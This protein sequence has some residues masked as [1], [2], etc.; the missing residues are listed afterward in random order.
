M[1]ELPWAEFKEQILSNPSWSILFFNVAGHYN[2][3]AKQNQFTVVCKLYKDN[4][5]DQLD[6]E[7]NFKPSI[8]NI[9]T[10]RNQ[11]RFE[12]DDIRNAAARCE[13]AIDENKECEIVIKIPGESS[14][15]IDGGFVFTDSYVPGDSVTS[16]KVVDVDNILGQGAEFVVAEYHDPDLPSENQ[17]WYMWPMPQVGGEI[18]ITALGFYGEIPSGFYLEIYFKMMPSSTA[19]KVFCNLDWGKQI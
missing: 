18:E 17:G 12:R 11:T 8:S 2:I 19:T 5:S 3:Y 4:G 7:E 9:I 1:I 16:I 10:D 13:A 6:F 14:R 15:F